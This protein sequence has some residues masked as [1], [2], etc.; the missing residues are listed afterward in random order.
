MN[1][2]TACRRAIDWHEWDGISVKVCVILD[3]ASRRV[4][5]GGEFLEINTEE[6]IK[7]VVDLTG[8]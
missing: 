4:L 3:G 6:N 2:N 8:G 5:A 1:E 7:L